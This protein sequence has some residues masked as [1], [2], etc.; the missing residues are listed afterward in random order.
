[1]S[2]WKKLLLGKI[3]WKGH[4]MVP[5]GSSPVNRSLNQIK[6]SF[7]PTLSLSIYGNNFSPL[8]LLDNDGMEITFRLLGIIGG[9]R[10]RTRKIAIAP[11]LFVGKSSWTGMAS[12]FETKLPI[13]LSLSPILLIHFMKLL[14]TST[15]LLSQLWHLKLFTEIIIWHTLM[16]L[17]KNKDVG[18][19]IFLNLSHRHSYP[20]QMSFRVGTNNYVELITIR[21]L[22]HCPLEHDCRHHHIFGTQINIIKL[23]NNTYTCHVHTLRNILDE[24]MHLK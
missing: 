21:H 16:D 2:L 19:G 7:S 8:W 10:P 11:Y 14:M 24:S 17:H 13:G 4:L 12:Y 3:W 23:F 6:V 15:L 9:L 5:P 1:M 18:V 22:L 20:I